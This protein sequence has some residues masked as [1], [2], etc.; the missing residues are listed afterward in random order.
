MEMTLAQQTEELIKALNQMH[1][2]LNFISFQ[3]HTTVAVLLLILLVAAVT[4]KTL[5]KKL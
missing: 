2:D 1:N 3:L 5:N 4:L